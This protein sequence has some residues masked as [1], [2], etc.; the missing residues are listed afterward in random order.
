MK[1]DNKLIGE[2]VAQFVRKYRKDHLREREHF[3]AIRFLE[4]AIQGAV[5]YNPINGKRWDHFWNIPQDKLDEFKKLLLQDD[6]KRELRS[7]VVFHDL[8]VRVSK[9]AET[10]WK[11]GEMVTYDVTDRIGA[12]LGLAPTRV[13]LHRG[14]RIGTK[15]L[16]FSGKEESLDPRDLIALYPALDAL[17]PAEMEDFLCLYKDRFIGK[18]KTSRCKSL[19]TPRHPEQPSPHG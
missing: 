2:L 11:K 17:T 18:K 6:V 8:F 7:A 15:R 5:S 16:G 19:G 4:V 12:H 3:R 13:Y 10:L 14:T 1:P 9:V